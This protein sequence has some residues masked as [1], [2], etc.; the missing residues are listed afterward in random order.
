M[1]LQSPPH[2]YLLFYNCHPVRT[3]KEKIP[4]LV[5]SPKSSIVNPTSFQT[6]NAFWGV[7]RTA[8]EQSRWKA[9]MVA[10]CQGQFGS[11]A[12]SKIP[13]TH[14][15]STVHIHN[16]K[17]L[18]SADQ[19]HLRTRQCL[20]QFFSRKIRGSIE[21]ICSSETSIDEA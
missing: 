10:Q 11:W 2:I 18:K 17:A 16:F 6:G 5:R 8:V 13:P 19:Q 20:S 7:V 14:K 21:Y 1:T 4:V 12:N 9:N 15:K 3:V